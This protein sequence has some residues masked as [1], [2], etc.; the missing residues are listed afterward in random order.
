MSTAEETI[1]RRYVNIG[2]GVSLFGFIV[3]IALFVWY[4]HTYRVVPHDYATIY[5]NFIWGLVQGFFVLPTFVW[6]LFNHSVAIY[7]TPNNGGW[8]NF[9]Y[10]LGIGGF[11]GGGAS[12]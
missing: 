7:Q 8:Y 10:I 9:G 11:F 2:S 1:M 5:N 4:A 3:Y 12:I 6:S